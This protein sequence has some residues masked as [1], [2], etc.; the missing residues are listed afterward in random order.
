MWWLDA[1]KMKQQDR[2]NK[3]SVDKDA[4]TEVD[5]TKLAQNKAFDEAYATSRKLNQV[6]VENGFTIKIYLATGGKRRG[7]QN[8]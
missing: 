7:K 5:N 2:L 8:G 6:L 1:R 3:L 4:S